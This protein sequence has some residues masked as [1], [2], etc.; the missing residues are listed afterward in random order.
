MYSIHFNEKWKLKGLKI[1][2]GPIGKN[3]AVCDLGLMA[4]TRFELYF[5]FQ[6]YVP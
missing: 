4:L 2:I 6:V 5:A 1:L 3:S